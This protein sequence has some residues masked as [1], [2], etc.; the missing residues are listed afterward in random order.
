MYNIGVNNANHLGQTTRVH[1]INYVIMEVFK[2]KLTNFNSSITSVDL[3][4]T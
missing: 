1:V 4:I 2:L 3:R